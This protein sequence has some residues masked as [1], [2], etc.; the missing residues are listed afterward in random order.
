MHLHLEH[1]LKMQNVEHNDEKF[2][3]EV[4]TES[5]VNYFLQ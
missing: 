4:S 5:N 1:I 3:T 2:Y